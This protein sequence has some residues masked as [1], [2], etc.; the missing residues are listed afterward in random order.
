MGF[1]AGMD[2]GGVG[3]KE[4]PPVERGVVAPELETVIL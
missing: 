4:S 1:A 3:M 2:A